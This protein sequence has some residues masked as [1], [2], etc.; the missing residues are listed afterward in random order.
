MKKSNVFIAIGISLLLM[1]LFS[2]DESENPA[3]P[4]PDADALQALTENNIEDQTQ[5]FT[6]D[7]SIGGDIKGSKGTIIQFSDDAFLTQSGEVV[8]GDR[9]SVV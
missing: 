6:I 1:A 4:T 3:K 9:K 7:A 2:C 5:H 8:T